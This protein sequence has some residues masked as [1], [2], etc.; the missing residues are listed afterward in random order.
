MD[1]SPIIYRNT[2]CYSFKQLDQQNQAPKGTGFRAF[3]RALPALIEEVDYFYLDA[4]Q[5]QAVIEPLRE[6]G[7]IYRSTRHLVLLTAA[8]CQRVSS[9]DG[10]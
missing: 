9:F 2:H 7:S 1:F 4:Q 3:K 10:C 8:G 6:A 5:Q